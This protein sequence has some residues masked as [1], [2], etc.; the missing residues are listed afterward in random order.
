MTPVDEQELAEAVAA[1]NHPLV[2]RGGGTRLVGK[3]IGGEELSV[4]GLTGIRQYEPE[5]LTLVT[6]AGTHLAEI[7]Q[8]LAQERQR[9]AFE[10]MD[11]R[12]LLKTSGE[13]T[14]GGVV[15]ANING[16][17]R[18]QV[19]ACRDHLLGVRF[20]D[21][22]GNII[23][24][25]GRVMKNVTGYDLVRL[26]AGSFGTLGVLTEIAIKVLPE[27]ECNATLMI[28]ELSDQDA[29]RALAVGLRS[30]FEVTGA[31]H[32]PSGFDGYPTTFIRVEGFE[33]SVRYRTNQ[34]KQLLSDFGEIEIETN[35]EKNVTIWK[36]VRDVELFHG[37]DGDVWK[38]SVKPS[39]GSGIGSLIKNKTNAEFLYDWGGGLI[40]V[41]VTEGTDLRAIIGAI[42][43]HA[44]LVRATPETC[45]H[46]SM[47][48]SQPV[49]LDL[50]SK[51][52]RNKFDPNQI[53]NP[54]LMG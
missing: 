52:L 1:A 5:A 53:L 30:P 23:K 18:V 54:G 26:L 27:S 35:A 19:G 38:I 15:A 11:H 45:S 14:I 47:F 31:A 42:N 51:N 44:T 34:L 7:E 33:D 29:L 48:H 13:S 40:W 49:L 20:V 2:I 4:A 24:N 16:P 37:K 17:R 9:L 50:L 12:G 39:D 25:G 22:A 21:G 28:K 6:S 36:W 46:L 32:A 8:R 43:G 10:P 3:T 41:L